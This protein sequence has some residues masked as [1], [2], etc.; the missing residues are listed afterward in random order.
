M[1]TGKD[2]IR[3]GAKEASGVAKRP[4]AAGKMAEGVVCEGGQVWDQK[5]GKCVSAKLKKAAKA[6]KSAP[7]PKK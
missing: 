5:L 6:L 4:K 7:I 2:L 1:P 3:K